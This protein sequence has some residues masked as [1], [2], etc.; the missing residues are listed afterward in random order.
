MRK[1]SSYF[2]GFLAAGFLTT[3]VMTACQKDAAV[4]TNTGGTTPATT[5]LSWTEDF[6]DVPSLTSRGWVMKNNSSPVG[7]QGWRQGR[8]EANPQPNKKFNASTVGFAAYNATN[9][10][11]D[12]VS[13][14]VTCVNTN[15]DISAWLI[16]PPMTI[17][18]GD[19]LSFYTRTQDDLT[20]PWPIYTKDDMEVRANF[21]DG[22]SNV[23]TTATN[24][25]SFTTLLLRMNPSY[26]ENDNG[27]YPV[28]DW[29]KQTIT[30]SGLTGTVTNARIAFRYRGT[31]AGLSGG[32]SGGNFASIVGVDNVVFTS[33]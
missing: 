32:T 21:T 1:N 3:A 7:A 8:Y 24:V 17:K 19:K 28:L 30:F 14:D 26:I 33:N 13:C 2:F 12:F 4:A 20:I 11:N 27:G 5:S 25:G 22:S 6:N 23:G 10:P 18:N 16:T 15:G 9:T 29:A 31:D